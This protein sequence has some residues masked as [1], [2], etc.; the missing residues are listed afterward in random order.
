MAVSIYH[1]DKD[2]YEIPYYLI[3]KYKDI[4]NFEIRHYSYGYNETV[5]YALPK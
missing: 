1:G 4:Y 5:L 3:K 2:F